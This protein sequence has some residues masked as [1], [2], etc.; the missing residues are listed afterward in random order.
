MAMWTALSMAPMA[1]KRAVGMAVALQVGARRLVRQRLVRL[2]HFLDEKRLPRRVGVLVGVVY[3]RLRGAGRRCQ[4]CDSVAARWL[5]MQPY[6][7]T[8]AR[9][10]RSCRGAEA[11]V[12][13]RGTR[14]R[15]RYLLLIS[16]SVALESSPRMS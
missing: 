11:S 13:Q 7:H 14:T 12:A 15:L 3:P 6:A 10:A 8:V 1:V 2:L 9:V 5:P 4:R 16:R